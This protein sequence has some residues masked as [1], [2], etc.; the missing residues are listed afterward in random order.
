MVVKRVGAAVR[1]DAE[2]EACCLRRLELHGRVVD[3]VLA[4]VLGGPVSSE[5]V[6]C[7]R[8]M[9]VDG[10][11][12]LMEDGSCGGDVVRIFA[13]VFYAVHCGRF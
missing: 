1:V 10:L 12:G 11:V 13:H 2:H 7:T 8:R 5:L 9:V 3:H 4:K 6:L